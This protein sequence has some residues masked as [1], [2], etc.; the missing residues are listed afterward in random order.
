MKIKNLLLLVISSLL[1]ASCNTT[2]DIPYV[3]NAD[4]LPQ[5]V[6]QAAAKATDPVIMPGDMLQIL[7]T[8]LNT[9]AVKPFNKT[10]YIST[11]GSASNLYT[12]GDQGNS[13][14]YY[15]VDAKG[16]IEF[17]MLGKLHIGGL[18]KSAIEE[19]IASLIY[20]KYLTEKPGVEVRL[21]NFRVYVLGD[22]GRPG[23]VT[24]SNERLNV[25]EAISQSG[26]LNITGKRSNIMLIRTNVD[27]SYAVHR[28][29]LNDKNLIVSPDYNL[30]Q[31]D[32]IYVEP[33]ASKARS[34]WNVPPALSLTV[35]SIGTL[36]SIATFIITLT[37]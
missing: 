33:N 2:K 34:S 37:K 23:V 35:G 11:E 27:G 18:T 6:L 28:L 13:I 20:P 24:A 9:E 10:A 30:Q 15:L 7:V 14:F 4:Q 21:K 17:P 16:Y 1:L 8:S 36:I 12:S 29:N 3:I 19:Q 26:D 25:L 31:N 5:D 22:V 32:I